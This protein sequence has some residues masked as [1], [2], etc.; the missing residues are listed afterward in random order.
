MEMPCGPRLPL[1]WKRPVP[2]STSCFCLNRCACPMWHS[3]ALL[4]ADNVCSTRGTISALLACNSCFE[5]V[6]GTQRCVLQWQIQ[7]KTFQ[8]R[9][10]CILSST[11]STLQ[12]QSTSI[13]S[14]STEI[15]YVSLDQER[16]HCSHVKSGGERTT[17]SGSFMH[18]KHN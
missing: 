13:I 2:N 6:F 15:W 16:L 3:G 7:C 12:L 8:V 9:F 4:L 11:V 17:S 14:M 5:G 10:C 18:P 1:C